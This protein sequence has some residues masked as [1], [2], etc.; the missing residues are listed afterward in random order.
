MCPGHEANGEFAG[1]SGNLHREWWRTENLRFSLILQIVENQ[2][3]K[4]GS[5][6]AGR[7]VHPAKR[8]KNGG[9]YLCESK[10]ILRFCNSLIT[11]HSHGDTG[12]KAKNR[13][14]KQAKMLSIY[15]KTI[16]R[17]PKRSP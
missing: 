16:P 2:R 4:Q 15:Q 12:I 14:L 7:G 9:A 11:K 8:Q 5:K 6:K 10:L 1:E 17:T 13:V 3:S